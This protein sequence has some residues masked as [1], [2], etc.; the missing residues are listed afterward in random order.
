MWELA[1][2]A[3]TKSDA[4]TRKAVYDD[5][6]RRTNGNIAE[7]QF[8]ALEV[9]N[10]GRRG[11]S[12]LMKMLTAWI[13]FLNAR[14]QG[15]DVI[16]RSARGQYSSNK[17]AEKGAR[18]RTFIIRGSILSMLT[19]MYYSMVSDD[20]E[21]EKQEDYVRDNNWIIPTGAIKKAFGVEIDEPLKMPIPFEIGLIFKTLPERI[22]RSYE[23]KDT[24]RKSLESLT[25]AV[26]LSLIHI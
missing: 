23:D 13:P 1:G 9:L 22:I 21:Y 6:M 11:Y 4:A 25:R 15:L 17:Q 20:D 18:M 16:N 10:Y 12:P 24:A 7:A 5:V 19:A 3:T 14:L 2:Q 26:G 8:Q